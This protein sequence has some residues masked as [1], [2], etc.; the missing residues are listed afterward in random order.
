MGP[1]AL[2]EAGELVGLV[3]L[4]GSDA[5][6][7]GV[8]AAAW[9]GTG[10]AAAEWVAAP[11]DGSQLALSA[12]VLGD[13]SWLLVW[14][15]FDGGDDEIRWSRRDGEAWSAPARLHAENRVPDI[16]PVV[17]ATADG[18]IAAWSRYD[19]GSYRG[20]VMRF[21]AATGWRD[22]ERI[23]GPH[24]VFPFFAA[25]DS[26]QGSRARLPRRGRRSL[27]SDRARRARRGAGAL[28][29]RR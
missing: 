21:D 24:S 26:R 2:V 23:G 8:R 13:G 1:Q 9:N 19:A 3:W 25:D 5:S 17:A 12:A 18:A 6:A 4:E 11:I 28:A 29:L 22:E 15:A 7:L 16:T 27:G 20:R 10:F 14:S